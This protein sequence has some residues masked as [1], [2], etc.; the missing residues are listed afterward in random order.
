MGDG[1]EG[2]GVGGVGGGWGDGGGWMVIT[3]MTVKEI[4]SHYADK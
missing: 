2:A 3:T 4:F 1:G